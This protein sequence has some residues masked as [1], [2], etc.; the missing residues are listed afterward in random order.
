LADIIMT[1]SSYSHR[2]QVCLGAYNALAVHDSNHANSKR[3]SP[4]NDFA[5][6]LPSTPMGILAIGNLFVFQLIV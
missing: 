1:Y 5:N 6:I 2:L 3:D 4:M